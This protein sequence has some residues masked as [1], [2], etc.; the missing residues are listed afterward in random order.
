[1][2]A[3]DIGMTM[4]LMSKE[5]SPL[6]LLGCCDALEV[7]RELVLAGVEFSE[8]VDSCRTMGLWAVE[9]IEPDR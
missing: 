6:L 8:E 4:L 9:A 7:P 3:T 1:M 5:L 2:A